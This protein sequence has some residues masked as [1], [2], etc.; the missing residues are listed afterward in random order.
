[1]AVAAPAEVAWEL[2]ADL[3]SWR[4]WNPLYA[5]TVGSFIVGETIRMTVTVP[6]SRPMRFGAKVTDV[7]PT[8]WVEYQ[9]EAVGGLLRGT[10]YIGIERSGAHDCVV[11]N[12]EII[13]GLLGPVIARGT[14]DRVLSGL[15][16]MSEALQKVA[17]ARWQ[18]RSAGR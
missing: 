7:I 4:Q 18:G 1:M 3:Q 16:M 8:E 6:G 2:I 12:G 17:E 11:S 14:R 10:R 9:G 15:Q 13:G 5:Q